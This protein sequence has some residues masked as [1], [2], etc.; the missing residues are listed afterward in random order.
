M[1][2]AEASGEGALAECAATV[3]VVVSACAQV[4]VQK[5][6]LAVRPIAGAGRQGRRQAAQLVLGVVVEAA[7]CVAGGYQLRLALAK[8]VPAL[9]CAS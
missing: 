7:T 1:E 4:L 8:A 6:H 5:R 2:P 3:Q 9:L